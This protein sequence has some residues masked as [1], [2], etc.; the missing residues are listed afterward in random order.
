MLHYVCIDYQIFLGTET[1]L[2]ILYE[3]IAKVD[4]E[5]LVWFRFSIIKHLNIHVTLVTQTK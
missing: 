2:I 1:F 4:K 3:S 5:K